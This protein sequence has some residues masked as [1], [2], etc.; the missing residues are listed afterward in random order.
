[1]EY[2]GHPSA[3][4]VIE[5]KDVDN[6]DSICEYHCPLGSDLTDAPQMSNEL[7]EEVLESTLSDLP[8]LLGLHVVGCPK[9]THLAIFRLVSHTP[10]L[11][12]LAFT[13]TVR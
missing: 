10:R 6:P 11:E 3:V 1:M 8:Q 12:S 9:V 7:N 13:V 2:H 4:D 5:S